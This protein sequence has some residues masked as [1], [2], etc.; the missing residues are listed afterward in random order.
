MKKKRKRKSQEHP[1]ESKDTYSNLSKKKTIKLDNGE[2]ISEYEWKK[3]FDTQWYY[4]N[5][6]GNQNVLETEEQVKESTR[7]NNCRDRDIIVRQDA[8][9]DE[10]KE[11]MLYDDDYQTFMNDANDEWDWNNAF[12]EGGYELAAQTIYDQTIADLQNKSLDVKVTLTRFIIK[13]M[14]LRTLERREKRK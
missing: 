1:L 11:T 7:N 8:R 13:I 12:K 6:Y 9:D 2:I 3:R 4:G 5:R 10:D 14:N